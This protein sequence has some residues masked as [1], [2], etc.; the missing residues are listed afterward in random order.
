MIL[1][2]KSI[3]LLICSSFLIAL[4]VNFFIAVH[5]LT[6]GGTTGMAISLSIITG[7]EIA[8]A[9]LIITIPLIIIGALLLGQNYGLKTVIIVIMSPIFMNLLPMKMLIDNT[10][11]SGIVGGVLVGSAIAIAI[12]NQCSTG[13]TDLI[14]M[15]INK[16]IPKIKI[17]S[18]LLLI[19]GLVV[20][21][22]SF[23]TGKFILALYSAITLV[24]INIT[25]KIILKKMGVE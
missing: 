25:I 4:A 22:S 13:G 17:S 11:V 8:K 20:I 23:L 16:Y 24:I 2:I 18:W 14:A 21:S 10:L 3:F 5:D 19:D 6:P 1:K 7:I 9:S 15:L 12:T